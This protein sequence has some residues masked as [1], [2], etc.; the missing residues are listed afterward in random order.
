MRE[1]VR[2]GDQEA[3]AQARQQGLGHGAGVDPAGALEAADDGRGA[4]GVEHQLAVRLVLDQGDVELVEQRRHGVALGLAVAHGGRVLE[5]RNQVG[6]GRLVLLQ[7]LAQGLQFRAVGFLRHGD[8]VGAEQLEGLQ[9]GQVGRR[10]DQDLGTRIDKQL[11]RQVQGLLR[12]AGDQHLA[13]IAV[14]SQLARLR[15]HRLAQRRLALA[16]AVLADRSR[17]LAPVHF[18]QHRLGGQAAGEGHHLR[19]LRRGEDFA[20]QGAFQTGNAFGEGHGSHR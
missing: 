19:T 1:Q 6:E 11:A 20:D 4:A 17:H 8:A 10:L 2:A 7:A 13:G 18:R 14:H 9:R 12:A 3:D 15:G 16:H 5:G